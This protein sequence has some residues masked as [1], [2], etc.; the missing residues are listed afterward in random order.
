MERILEI[1]KDRIYKTSWSADIKN[2]GK[3]KG[4]LILLLLA[5]YDFVF[6]KT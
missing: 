6:L 1:T 5:R 4:V 3:T 2:L